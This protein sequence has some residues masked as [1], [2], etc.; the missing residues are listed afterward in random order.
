MQGPQPPDK[1]WS[2]CVQRDE[3]HATL[4]LRHFSEAWC[5]LWMTLVFDRT[6]GR[7]YHFIELIFDRR[8][9]VAS[10]TIGHYEGSGLLR[11]A[12]T[13][14]VST[15]LRD[16]HRAAQREPDV[17]YGNP[18]GDR[19]I[20]GHAPDIT[21]HQV[22]R[23]DSAVGIAELVGDSKPEFTQTHETTLTPLRQRLET[24]KAPARGRGFR[25]NVL[26]P[27]LT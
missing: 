2:F 10:R 15:I 6:L 3:A 1:G 5:V 9:R 27:S 21:Q 23:Q 11:F 22:P 20:G 12:A 19:L 26:A 24:T 18:C 16:V 7:S 14:A 25:G 8:R 17:A 13:H 4:G